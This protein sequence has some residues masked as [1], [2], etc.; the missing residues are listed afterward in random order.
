MT[1]LFSLREA[2]SKINWL[3]GWAKENGIEIPIDYEGR[4]DISK[5]LELYE[6]WKRINKSEETNDTSQTL[7]KA[8]GFADRKRKY[9][10]DHI[11][12]SKEM[13][14]K[15]QDEYE[16][17]AIDFWDNGQGEVYH[18]SKRGRF[19]KFNKR[20]GEYVVTDKDGTLRTYYKLPLKQFEKKV[21]QEGY[22]KWKK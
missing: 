20:T 6:E 3:F 12:H 9:S 13:G 22:K 16:R 11:Q 21:K 8:F 2:V 1:V 15:N 14:F 17:A 5:L 19:A 10:P 4:A 18:G 7:G